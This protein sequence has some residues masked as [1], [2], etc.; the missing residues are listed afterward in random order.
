MEREDAWKKECLKKISAMQKQLDELRVM[1]K[2]KEKEETY[3]RYPSRNMI[4]PSSMCEFE[5]D[6]V[7][8]PKKEEPSKGDVIA[9]KVSKAFHEFT[10]GFVADP[11]GR[12]IF[13]Q[14]MREE[15]KKYDNRWRPSQEG[16][17][18][19]E[20][21]IPIGLFG[22]KIDIQRVNTDVEKERKRH[23]LPPLQPIHKDETQEKKKPE[24]LFID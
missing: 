9:E 18:P 19:Q 4:P 2:T 13:L 14:K 21:T 16:E 3:Q 10:E 17:S 22:E 6:F 24:I 15:M 1:I 11:R 12:E 8:A 7:P 5:H 20:D 23:G